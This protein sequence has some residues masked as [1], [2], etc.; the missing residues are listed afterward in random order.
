MPLYACK[1][2][3]EKLP[4]ESKPRLIRAKNKA[5]ALAFAVSG[6]YQAEP[7]DNDEVFKLAKTG[8][9]IETVPE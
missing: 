8:V 2:N 1:P 9:E 5:A 7:A 6:F 3:L 4:K